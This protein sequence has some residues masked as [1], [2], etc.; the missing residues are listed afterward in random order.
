M[1]QQAVAPTKE[2]QQAAAAAA[3][4]ATSQSSSKS[5]RRDLAFSGLSLSRSQ[6]C[7]LLCQL[8][9]MQVLLLLLVLLWVQLHMQPVELLLIVTAMQL[10]YPLGHLV[11]CQ[12]MH[13]YHQHSSSSH[14][15]SRRRSSSSSQVTALPQLPPALLR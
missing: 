2:C 8:P 7:W 10:G 9:A 15:S 6:T 14:S 4:L 1:Q 5:S 11:L 3:R 12:A 13:P